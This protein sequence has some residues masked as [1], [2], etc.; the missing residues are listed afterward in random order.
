M[1]GFAGRLAEGPMVVAAHR[2]VALGAE[3]EHGIV[4]GVNRHPG[5]RGFDDRRQGSA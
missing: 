1:E 4:G 3:R 2:A 5:H